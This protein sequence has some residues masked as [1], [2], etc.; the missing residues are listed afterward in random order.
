MF[1][2]YYIAESFVFIN[3][4]QFA[5]ITFPLVACVPATPRDLRML[6]SVID[7]NIHSRASV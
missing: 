4:V 2:V 6:S 5:A 1:D 7:M 3:F